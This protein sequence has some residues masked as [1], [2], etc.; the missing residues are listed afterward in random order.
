LNRLK[1]QLENVKPTNGGKIELK[2]EA[3]FG[4]P[5]CP[6]KEKK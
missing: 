5:R 6:N 3:H 1:P 4:G 2:G